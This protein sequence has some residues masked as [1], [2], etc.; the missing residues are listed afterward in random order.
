[1]YDAPDPDELLDELAERAA[2]EATS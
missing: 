2:R 1:M